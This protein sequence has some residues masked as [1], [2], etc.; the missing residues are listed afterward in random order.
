M[1]GTYSFFFWANDT[2]DNYDTSSTDTF[3]IAELTPPEISNIINLTSDPIDTDPAYGWVNVSCDVVDN[4]EVDEVSLNITNPDGSDNNVSMNS[5][6]SDSYYYN[7]TTAFSTY[8]NYSYFVWANDTSGNADVSSSYDYSMPPN[9]DV[10]MNGECKVYDLTL[11]SNHYE[12]TGPP[13]WI[14]E[15]VDNNG[16]IQ[17]LDFVFVSNHYNESWWV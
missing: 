8:G 3:T 2:S 9:W 6:D 14:R 5:G 10:D 17:I 15:D 16:V 4:I 11:I 7:S 13:G 1:L 12:E